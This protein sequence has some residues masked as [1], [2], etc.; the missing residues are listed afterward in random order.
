MLSPQISAEVRTAIDARHAVVALESTIFSNLGLP[1][2]ANAEALDRCIA[3][4]RGAGAVPAV[5]AILDGVARVGLDPVEHDRILGPATEGR[6]ARS[7]G[8][9]G[10][11]LGLRGDHRERLGGPRRRCRGRGL[12]HRRDRR[13]A[14]RRRGHG[15]HLRRPR[16]PRRP[17]GDH[18]Q[19]RGQGV[20][21]PRS[22]A[23]VPRDPRRAR[24]RLA[25]RLVPGVLH[26]VVG[27]R[28]PASGRGCGDR[29]HGLRRTH[30]R[31]RRARGGADP[32]RGRARCCRHRRSARSRPRGCRG[33]AGSAGQR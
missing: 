27:A 21:R 33:R 15:R 25:A 20:P 8:R 17:P 32:R 14:P 22:D 13:R 16:R 23:R 11:A 24:A 29:R 12:R 9:H 18:R 28:R 10:P 3:A 19:R 31:S 30:A 1:S 2:P 5:T 26:A 6:R 7:P 4:I